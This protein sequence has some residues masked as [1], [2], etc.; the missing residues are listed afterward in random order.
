[1]QCGSRSAAAGPRSTS[2]ARRGRRA[3]ASTRRRSTRSPSV[4]VA[5][6]YLLDPRGRFTSG[7]LRSVDLVIPEGTVVSALPPDGAVFAYW[8]QSQ[9]V[10]SAMLRALA[11]AVGE[12]AMAGDRG[13][14]DLHNANGVWPDGTPWVSAAQ[15]GG[16]IGPYGATRDGDADSQM[17][18][19][20]ANGI[21]VAAEAVESDVPVVILRHEIVPDTGGPGYNRGGAAVLRDSLWLEP[22]EHHFMSLRYK[23]VAGFGV[24]GGGD[25]GTGGIWLWDPPADGEVAFTEI[26]ETSYADSTPVAGV[27]DPETNVPSRDGEYLYFLRK[28]SW[29]SDRLAVLRFVNCG[30]GGWGDPL[31]REPERVLLDVRDEYV[32]LE[33]A[34]RDYGVVVIGDPATDPEGLVVDAEATGRLRESL[35]AAR[36]ERSARR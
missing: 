30:G 34:A 1:M 22:A 15:C 29:R 10:M 18:S 11:Q 7:A 20:Q 27:L 4:G 13:C 31:D 5:L 36:D 32:T 12:G 17:L 8:E 24:S 35:R 23:R 21:A 6:K 2:A 19:Y 9:I 26:G 3:R 14:P 25:G 28:P 33:G 16:E